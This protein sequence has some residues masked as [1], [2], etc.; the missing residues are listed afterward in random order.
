MENKMT[1]AC[2][3]CSETCRKCAIQPGLCTE[4]INGYYLQIES[5]TCV[6]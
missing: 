3:R 2:D 1:N 4:C 6:K 5:N